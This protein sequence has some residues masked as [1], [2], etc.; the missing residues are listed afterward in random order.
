MKSLFF[1]ITFFCFNSTS[2]ANTF[3]PYDKAIIRSV[4]DYDTPRNYVDASEDALP[5]DVYIHLIQMMNIFRFTVLPENEVRDLF[6]DLEK[7]P[8]ARM[9]YP[10]GSCSIRRNYIQN[11][12]KQKNIVSGKLLIH[13]PAINGRLRLQ[14]QVSGHYYSF[15][16]FHDTNIVAVKTNTGLDFRVL[17]VQFEDTPVSLHE[18][19]SEIENS[20][21]VRPLKRKGTTRGLCYWTITT[22]HRSF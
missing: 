20:Q 12:L 1:L 22:P 15:A 21:K 8:N 9:R 13:C 2:I 3:E 14:D 5:Q 4:D 19:L 7:N 10:K 6:E 16:N 17:D 11:L 18:Y